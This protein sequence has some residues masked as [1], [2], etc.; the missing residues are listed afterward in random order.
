M[1]NLHPLLTGGGTII[2]F[3]RDICGDYVSATSREWL[4]TNGIG[5][6][7]SGTISGALTR[8]YHGLLVAALKPPLDRKLLFA[9]LDEIAHYD[10]ESFDLSTNQWVNVVEP[11]GYQFIE[12][13]YLDG[14][15]PVWN[16]AIA[17]A[18]L[19]KRIWMQQGANATY[20][21]FTLTRGLHPV[22]LTLKTLVNYRDYHGETQFGEHMQVEAVKDGIKIV[23]HDGATP[24]YLLS[25][26]AEA[27][28]RSE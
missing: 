19:E 6:Y 21:R 1:N 22:H 5:G 7:A 2:K 15:M 4:V 16:F 14:T 17:D 24:F 12:N 23:A 8:R 18:L 25:D 10:G 13:F 27:E 26:Q 20:I 11:H 3:G 28:I 9:K